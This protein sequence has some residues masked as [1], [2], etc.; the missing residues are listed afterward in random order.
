MSIYIINQHQIF[1]SIA[2]CGHLELPQ[3][4]EKHTELIEEQNK[5]INSEKNFFENYLSFCNVS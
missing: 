4:Y 1:W 2:N 5:Y 3:E